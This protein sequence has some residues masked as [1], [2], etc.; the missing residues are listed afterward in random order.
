MTLS[1]FDNTTFEK[2]L[3]LIPTRVCYVSGVVKPEELDE[4]K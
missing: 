3:K 4:I 2:H 1:D